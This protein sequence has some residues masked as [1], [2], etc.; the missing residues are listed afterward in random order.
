MSNDITK[1]LNECLKENKLIQ[2]TDKNETETSDKLKVDINTLAD[3]QL[4]VI[5]KSQP[6]KTGSKKTSFIESLKS[7]SRKKFEQIIL[8]KLNEPIKKENMEDV[9]KEIMEDVHREEEEKKRRRSTNVQ[10]VQTKPKRSIKDMFNLAIRS[11]R[12]SSIFKPAEKL[13]VRNM[14]AENTSFRKNTALKTGKEE[15]NLKRKGNKVYLELKENKEIKNFSDKIIEETIPEDSTD[16]IEVISSSP[17]QKQSTKQKPPFEV[18]V[19]QSTEENYAFNTF[20]LKNNC[21]PS[22][23][24]L[25]NS[26]TFAVPNNSKVFI[27]MAT[28][29]AKDLIVEV[30]AQAGKLVKKKTIIAKTFSSL[31]KLV[32]EFKS[33]STRHITKIIS[34]NSGNYKISVVYRKKGDNTETNT[35]IIRVYD[36]TSNQSLV[37]KMIPFDKFSQIIGKLEIFYGM[38]DGYIEENLTSMEKLISIAFINFVHLQTLKGQDN[39]INLNVTLVKR[40]VALEG[41]ILDKMFFNAQNS[42]V[43]FLVSSKNTLRAFIIT[44]EQ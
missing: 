18:N 4:P 41:I 43:E 38:A 24:I 26:N 13:K 10:M 22:Q 9:L 7:G 19:I 16:Q 15:S 11:D 8:G 30:R 27:S 2:N 20:F 6:A 25:F 12:I 44:K 40:P 21:R 1:Q 14:S 35:F 39:K 31:A 34:G 37:D 36:N 32:E 33:E 29:I 23:S 3:V 5:E 28:K 42:Q 17:Y